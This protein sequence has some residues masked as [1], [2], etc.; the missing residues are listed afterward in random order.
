MKHIVPR[1]S[2]ERARD[3]QDVEESPAEVSLQEIEILLEVFIPVLRKHQQEP[4]NA[5]RQR[6]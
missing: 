1:L 3:L 4:K 2:S 5:A 6:A